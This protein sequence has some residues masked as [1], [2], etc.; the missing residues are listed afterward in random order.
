MNTPRNGRSSPASVEVGLEGVH[1]AAEG[2]AAH[3]DVDDAEQRW[4][5]PIDDHR[6]R[7]RIMP[8][9]V[10]NAGRSPRAARTA[11]QAHRTSWTPHR[12]DQRVDRG[13][14]RPACGPDHGQ[15]R[16]GAASPRA[17]GRPD[18]QSRRAHRAASRVLPERRACSASTPIV[19][20]ARGLHGGCYQPRVSSSSSG[21]S[22][23]IS[24][25]GIGLAEAAGDLGED[26]RRR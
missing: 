17:R 20:A 4:S 15:R 16:A 8:A 18:L 2:V 5:R 9:Q 3:G 26:R 12:D 14:A 7:S 25:P 24:R 22:V 21:A 13:R 23:A 11:H 6:R 10:P 1:L 19:M